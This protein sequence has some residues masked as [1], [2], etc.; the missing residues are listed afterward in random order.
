[1]EKHCWL[2]FSS[3]RERGRV[4]AQRRRGGAGPPPPLSSPDSDP[5]VQ[6]ARDWAPIIST[7]LSPVIRGARRADLDLLDYH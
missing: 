5:A 2:T 4:V 3:P 6:Q 7:K 1:M